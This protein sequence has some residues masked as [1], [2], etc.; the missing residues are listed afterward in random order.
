MSDEELARAGS[1]A[2]EAELWHRGLQRAR[3]ATDKWQR[4][5]D[6]LHAEAEALYRTMSVGVAIF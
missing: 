1:A 2:Q 6:D 4:L 5:G 3:D